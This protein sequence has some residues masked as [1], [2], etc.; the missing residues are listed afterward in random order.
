MRL[1][2]TGTALL[3]LALLVQSAPA[4]GLGNEERTQVSVGRQSRM[5]YFVPKWEDDR[6]RIELADANLL[7]VSAAL[8]NARSIRFD[9]PMADDP[10]PLR[11]MLMRFSGDEGALAEMI[12]SLS[13]VG[14]VAS[15]DEAGG[16][17]GAQASKRFTLKGEEIPVSAVGKLL[18]RLFGDEIDL[19][20]SDPDVLVSIDIENATLEDIRNLLPELTGI[21]I[22]DRK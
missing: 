17:I 21:R 6:S 5:L 14:V 18:I 15:R 9:D 11:F 10:T 1:T 3:V 4:L 2:H 22:S 16:E 20:I 13:E 12:A 8:L 7:A 19:E